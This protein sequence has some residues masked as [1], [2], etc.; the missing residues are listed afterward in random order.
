MCRE[1]RGAGD[2]SRHVNTGGGEYII[3]SLQ[4]NPHTN[5]H[6]LLWICCCRFTWGEQWICCTLSASISLHVSV[7]LCSEHAYM[8]LP[9]YTMAV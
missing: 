8:C 5:L 6:D 2:V 4:E 7:S 1:D 3:L 9:V